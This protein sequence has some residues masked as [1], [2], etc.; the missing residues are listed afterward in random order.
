[1]GSSAPSTAAAPSTTEPQTTTAAPEST[2]PPST[3]AQP[4]ARADFEALDRFVAD[5]AGAALLIAEG[6][7]VVH[8]WYRDDDP[9]F[10]RDVA[11]AQKSVI[12]LLV[13]RA[14]DDGL[15]ALDTPI[16]DVLGPG[17]VPSGEATDVDVEQ[18]LST[19]S[20]LDHQLRKF[21]PPGEVWQ[22]SNAFAELADV[23]TAVT[24]MP[25]DELANDWLFEPAGATTATF[26]TRPS[27][28]TF[29]PFGLVASAADLAAI[30][31]LVLAGRDSAVS[32]DWIDAALSPSSQLN[33]SYG[34]L[35]W[36]NG[37]DGFRL[38]GRKAPL[39]PG[40]LVPTAP[41]DVVAALGKDDQ[42]L[43]VSRQLELVVVR[44]G[45]AADTNADEVLSGF[46]DELWSR[47]VAARG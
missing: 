12:A 18:L 41:S 29:A 8:E 9:G 47:L 26:R 39:Q 1:M 25:L 15:V 24:D 37:Q 10:R 31:A 3:V 4:W 43:Y 33:P 23:L 5:T 40:P 36:L 32:S 11:S 6:G 14:V 34:Y 17:W 45:D 16:V 35:W 19:T 28:G 21:A 46:D 42:K 30:G 2:E 38:P 27:D 44:L 7:C 20:G 13:G 22:Y